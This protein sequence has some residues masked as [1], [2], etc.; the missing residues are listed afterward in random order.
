MFLVSK[1]LSRFPFRKRKKNTNLL[2]LS[3]DALLNADRASKRRLAV[4]FTE[5]RRQQR[6]DPARCCCRKRQ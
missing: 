5:E 1:P 3:S 4:S 6:Q 2:T